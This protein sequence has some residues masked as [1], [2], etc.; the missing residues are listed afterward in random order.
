MLLDS[1]KDFEW[2]NEPRDV[3]FD[4]QG[5]HVVAFDGTDFWQ[6]TNSRIYKDN[7][8]FFFAKKNGDFVLK[9]K[10]KFRESSSFEQC[11]A[12]IRFDARNWMKISVLNDG[13]KGSKL[14]SVVTNAGFSDLA[15]FN[16][17]KDAREVW[18][19]IKRTNKDFS[20]FCSLDGKK[21]VQVRMFSFVNSH[22]EIK[23][24]AFICSPT[25]REF[26]AVLEQIEF[27]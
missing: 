6:N 3:S 8:H 12:M 15:V 21:F 13:T 25:N 7:G 14:G 10:W 24:G 20:V 22:D 4:E 2:Y 16:V 9:I 19:K 17:D 5:M 27:A 11:G 26:Y 1:L 18:Y 23:V